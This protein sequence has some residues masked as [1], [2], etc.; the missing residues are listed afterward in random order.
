MKIGDPQTNLGS[1]NHEQLERLKRKSGKIEQFLGAKDSFSFT[2]QRCTTCCRSRESNPILL[3]PYDVFR[4]TQSLQMRPSEWVDKYAQRALGSESELPLL[5]MKFKPD[6]VGGNQCRYVEASGCSIYKD[7]P[8]VCRLYPLGRIVDRDINSYFF[9]VKTASYCSPGK[10]KSQTLEDWL[11]KVEVEPYLYWNDKF[12]SLYLAMDF[13][14]YRNSPPSLKSAL[15]TIL[16]EFD[17]I[18]A[19]SPDQKPLDQ[20]FKE[21]DGR[22]N[23]SYFLAQKLIERCFK[24]KN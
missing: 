15:G 8:T 16:Y 11:T 14:K 1:L 2:C 22:L 4:M 19:L 10:E 18:E 23:A 7:R 6:K 13:E 20:C 17:R 9:K 21:P 24:Q 3:T 12:N 5:L